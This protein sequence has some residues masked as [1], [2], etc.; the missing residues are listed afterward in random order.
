MTGSRR[1]S[2]ALSEGDGISVLVHVADPAGA[3]AAEKQ[4]AEGLV[5]DRPAKGV[6]DATSLP[7]LFR[8]DSPGEATGPGGSPV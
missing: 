4:G 3:A 7:V 2:Q 6:R 5:L 1:L 8:G